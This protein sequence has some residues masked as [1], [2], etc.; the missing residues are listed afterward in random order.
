MAFTFDF[1]FL[2]CIKL[3]E[4][5]ISEILS[6]IAGSKYRKVICIRFDWVG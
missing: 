3:F 6:S 1:D 5:A 4:L 2:H